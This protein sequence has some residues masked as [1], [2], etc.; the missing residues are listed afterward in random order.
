MNRRLQTL[1][2][3][4]G[5]IVLSILLGPLQVSAAAQ[6]GQ[7]ALGQST[8]EPA[9]DANTGNTIFL[10]T[11]DKSPFPSKANQAAQDTMDI[12]MYPTDSTISADELDC[13]PTNCDHLHVVPFVPPGYTAAS[14]D[15]CKKWNGGA[16]C[17]LYKGH[18]HLVGAASTGGGF[19]VAW[20]VKLVIFTAKG[21]DDR[22]INT[23]ITKWTQLHQLITDG[24]VTVVDTPIVFNC[25]IVSPTT[26]AR[27]T[28]LTF[29]FP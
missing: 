8:I 22:A 6:T 3:L 15:V 12:P 23:R 21:F 17:A 13:Q 28:P 1:V 16:S 14:S 29:V 20:H 27:G 26:Y 11:P 24:D 9:V 19:N 2:S 10:L 5:L 18:D 4:T 25:Q 7:V